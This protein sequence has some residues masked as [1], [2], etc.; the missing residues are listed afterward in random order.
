MPTIALP[1]PP[2]RRNPK[3][4]ASA[5]ELGSALRLP[6]ETRRHKRRRFRSSTSILP[7]TRAGSYTDNRP[8]C[9]P[10][11][12]ACF[13]SVNPFAT[14]RNQSPRLRRLFLKEFRAQARPQPS[15]ATAACPTSLRFARKRT[16]LRNSQWRSDK[17]GCEGRLRSS[18]CSKLLGICRR[19]R[20]LSPSLAK[21]SLER[22]QG[23]QPCPHRQYVFIYEPDNPQ[24]HKHCRRSSS[25][26]AILP[27]NHSY[28]RGI[29]ELN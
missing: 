19:T 5:V 15:K 9:E 21:G 10:R 2:F 6:R 24:R 16:P 25:S 7:L 14:R 29:V 12:L 26:C 11:W 1:I 23:S 20:R 17:R 18:M 28:Y 22:Q 8:R 13:N 4:A 27:Q 3:P